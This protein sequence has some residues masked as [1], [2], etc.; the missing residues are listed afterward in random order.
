M[1][2]EFSR[3][4]RRIAALLLL[5]TIIGA[6]W[7]T[8]EELRPPP[9]PLRLTRGSPESDLPAPFDLNGPP[10]G[11]VYS[12][13][14]QELTGPI[15]IGAADEEMLTRLPGIGPVLARRIVEW[16][17]CRVVPWRIDDLLEVTGIGPA[18]LEMLR[19]FA[20]IDTASRDTTSTEAPQ[21]SESGGKWR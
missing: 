12:G 16:R 3:S 13:E 5:V 1:S 15:D 6:A 4:E 7:H 2:D 14:E 8:I 11:I 17:A 20:V 18:K 19:P 9:P 10:E 21:V